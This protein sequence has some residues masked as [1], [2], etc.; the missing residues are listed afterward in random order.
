MSK[1]IYTVVAC[2]E[3]D[4]AWI[5]SGIPDRT[6]CT[7]CNENYQF[8][9]LKNLYQTYDKE[10]AREARS[11]KQA[12]LNGVD[13]IYKSMLEKGMFDEEVTRAVTDEEYL[14][15]K[16]I[17]LDEVNQTTQE[18]GSR[19]QREIIEDGI[20]LQDEPTDESVAE[21]AEEHGIDPEKTSDIIDKMCMNGD[22]MRTRDG[23][24]RLL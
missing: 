10:E 6:S 20:E 13:H 21:Y 2:K 5:V 4:N 7:L 1:E 19:S 18:S 11:L 23:M 8:K 3:C 22:A 16:G 24:L 9:K 12:E 14:N 17:D 15:K